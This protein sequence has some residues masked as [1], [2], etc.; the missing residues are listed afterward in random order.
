[1]PFLNPHCELLTSDVV[2]VDVSRCGRVTGMTGWLSVLRTAFENWT[3]ASIAA[4]LDEGAHSALDCAR[5]IWGD[6]A[7][8][9]AEWWF[10]LLEDRVHQALVQLPLGHIGPTNLHLSPFNTYADGSTSD[11][12]GYCWGPAGAWLTTLMFMAPA[13]GSPLRGEIWK[14]AVEAYAPQAGSDPARELRAGLLIGCVLAAAKC[15][16][17]PER[18]LSERQSWSFEWL[19]RAVRVTTDET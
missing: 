6:S 19:R 18:A 13:D 3:G 15:S 14:A 9:P 4:G 11:W 16:L 8:A 2:A 12:S 7:E 1:V 5:R 10:E 17:T